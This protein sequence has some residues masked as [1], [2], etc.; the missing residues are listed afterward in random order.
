MPKEEEDAGRVPREVPLED[1]LRHGD[2]DACVREARQ[3][4]MEDE[5]D[6]IADTSSYTLL[7]RA[8]ARFGAVLRPAPRFVQHLKSLG[9]VPM[10]AKELNDGEDTR[11]HEAEDKVGE[12]CPEEDARA[13]VFVNGGIVGFATL[14]RFGVDDVEKFCELAVCRECCSEVQTARTV[15]VGFNV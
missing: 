12:S 4:E 3:K 5:E 10:E 13:E 15:S 8:H 2:V 14:A 1:I 7:F 9:P 6:H 11:G